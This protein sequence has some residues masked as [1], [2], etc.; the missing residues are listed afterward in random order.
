[1]LGFRYGE[2]FNSVGFV[3][4]FIDSH[5]GA[6]VA[7]IST[8]SPINA[9]RIVPN[10][11]EQRKIGID[12]V[13]VIIEFVYDMQSRKFEDINVEISP[14]MYFKKKEVETSEQTEK[15]E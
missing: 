10:I 6:E 12:D 8:T 14:Y 4:S 3:V 9:L 15:S 11:L 2:R 7:Q 13:K 1:M 5:S